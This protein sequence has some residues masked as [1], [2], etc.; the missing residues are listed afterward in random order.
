ARLTEV[1]VHHADL[2]A[3][4]THRDWPAGFTTRM[5]A[6]VTASY[7]RRDNA[8]DL[9]LRAT[10][11]GEEHGQGDHLVTGPATSLLAWLMGRTQGADLTATDNITLPFLY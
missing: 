3:G 6:S 9:R 2:D 5:L 7:A 11:T 4:F 1:L 10:D 8:P